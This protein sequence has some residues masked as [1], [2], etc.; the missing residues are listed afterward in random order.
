MLKHI[1]RLGLKNCYI[2]S[3]G[4]E[5]LSQSNALS[6]TSKLDISFNFAIKDS[7]IEILT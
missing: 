6:L 4:I 1:T 7:G 3:K 5:S 2:T